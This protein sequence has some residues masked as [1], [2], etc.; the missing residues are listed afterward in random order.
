MVNTFSVKMCIFL[1]DNSGA[2]IV[3]VLGVIFVVEI[4]RKRC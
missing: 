4:N 3:V 2:G 1:E